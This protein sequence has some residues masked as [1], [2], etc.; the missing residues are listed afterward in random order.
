MLQTVVAVLRFIITVVF[1]ALRPDCCNPFK[2]CV[3]LI[4][5]SFFLSLG[6]HHRQDQEAQFL[7]LANFLTL[8]ESGFFMWDTRVS[9]GAPWLVSC[10]GLAI[11]EGWDIFGG[12]SKIYTLKPV[13][14][15]PFIA[16]FMHGSITI[17]SSDGFDQR[18][19]ME[20]ASDLQK[21]PSEPSS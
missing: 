4:I 15:I 8:C 13:S 19:P 3:P 7:D 5:P 2:L 14:D 12:I 18:F 10:L 17:Y 1:C 6:S 21:E 11:L 9:I 16:F 20:I